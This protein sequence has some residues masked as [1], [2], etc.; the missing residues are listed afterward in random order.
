M[1]RKLFVPLLIPVLLLSACSPEELPAPAHQPGASVSSTTDMG[2]DYEYQVFYSLNENAVI[3]RN[4]KT[5]WDL[6]FECTPDGFHVILNSSKSMYA[7]NTGLQDMSGVADTSGFAGNKRPDASGG[8]LDSTAIGDWRAAKNVFLIDRGATVDG[9]VGFVKLRIEEV[10]ETGYT[11]S[12]QHINGQEVHTLRI[13]KDTLYNFTF[14]SFDQGGKIVDVAPPKDKWTLC[15]TQYTAEIPI[16]YLVTGV[17]LNPYRTAAAKDSAIDFEA[18]D[19]SY[20]Q[21][22]ELSENRDAIGYDWKVY[23]FDAGSYQVK[24]TMNY[25]IKA[26]DGNYYKLHFIDFYNPQGVKGN[27]SWVCSRL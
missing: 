26:Q 2:S 5:V 22:K 27:P 9:P 23:D 19:L 20:A 21:Q 17:L 25:I 24:T 16:P 7:G 12:F 14:L 15:F 10:D 4:L 1:L 18:I 6:G 8:S 13:P 3:S 11:I